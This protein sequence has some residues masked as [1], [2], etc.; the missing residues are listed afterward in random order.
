MFCSAG[1]KEKRRG[2]WS[3][4]LLSNEQ[5]TVSKRRDRSKQK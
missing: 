1:A 2:G 4:R 5:S 3:P